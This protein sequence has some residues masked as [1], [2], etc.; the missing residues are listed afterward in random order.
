MESKEIT[1]LDLAKGAT[2]FKQGHYETLG[3][4]PRNANGEVV[5]L[6]GKTINVVIVKGR[7]VVYDVAGTYESATSTIQFEIAENIGYGD[8]WMEI[9]VTDPADAGYRQKFPTS[10]YDGRLKFIRSSDDAD[11]VGFS[12]KTIVQFETDQAEFKNTMQQQF[13]LA[14]AAISPDAEVALARKDATTL[15][16]RLDADKQE[17]SQQLAEKI[18]ANTSELTLNNFTETDRAVI[19]GMAPGEINAVLGNGNVVVDNLNTYL[20]DTIAKLNSVAFKTDIRNPK[21]LKGKPAIGSNLTLEYLL[22]AEN[23]GA[24]QGNM[25]LKM[26]YFTPST[27]VTILKIT[28]YQ[29]NDATPSSATGGY[30]QSVTLENPII[31]NATKAVDV[32]TFTNL[33]QYRYKHVFVEFGLASSTIESEASVSNFN[34][35]VGTVTLPVINIGKHRMTETSAL[36]SE[37]HELFGDLTGKPNLLTDVQ[38]LRED[39]NEIQTTTVNKTR[40]DGLKAN[41][42][43]DS[44]TDVTHLPSNVKY[45]THLQSELKLSTVRAYGKASS[46]IAKGSNTLEFGPMCERYLTMDNDADLVTVFAGTNDYGY[47]NAIISSFYSSGEII[48]KDVTTFFGACHVLFEGLINKYTNRGTSILIM[49][50]L[51]RQ[52]IMTPNPTTGLYLKDYVAIIKEVASY[53][54]LPVLDLFEESGL[55]SRVPAI[56]TKYVPD[57][58]HPNTLGHEVIGNR[59]IGK[60]KTL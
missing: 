7:S 55:Q 26:N 59:L 40:F 15:G 21:K 53:Y 20:K 39:V 29:N 25:Q 32:P 3:F 23:T 44:I 22:D 33:T 8:M 9:T 37:W 34:L 60:L 56:K 42:L 30:G 1:R 4:T 47:S 45:F 11:Y 27:N 2:I 54:S 28:I 18:D 50:P 16:L 51:P 43:G 24:V 52:S 14:V 12:G 46:T 10:E 41:F 19:Q 13:D 17:L 6:T 38:A 36:T 35:S 49:T 48:N 5:D 58:V 57:G 31:R